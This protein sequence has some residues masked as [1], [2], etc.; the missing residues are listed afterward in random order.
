[1]LCLFPLLIKYQIDTR[2]AGGESA[3]KYIEVNSRILQKYASFNIFAFSSIGTLYALAI[4]L[5]NSIFPDT[6]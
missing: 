3:G 6:S 5:M 1:M 4:V 2:H